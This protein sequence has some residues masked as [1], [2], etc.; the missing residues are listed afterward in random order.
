MYHKRHEGIG[1]E[2]REQLSNLSHEVA[3]LKKQ[4]MRRGKGAFH[5]SRHMGE[6]I[7]ELL[8]DYY[9]ALPDL[10]RSAHRL[11]KSAEANPAATA[12]VAAAAVVLVGLAASLL[13][14]RR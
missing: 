2:L 12:G 13:L 7:G 4:M 8:R 9:E 14:R 1:D 11:Q 10:R 3:Q 5:G 6:E